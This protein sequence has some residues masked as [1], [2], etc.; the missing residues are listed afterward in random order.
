MA[1]YL[2]SCICKVFLAMQIYYISRKVKNKN[3]I[4]S[5]TINNKQICTTISL[6]FIEIYT[7]I[8]HGYSLSCH[9]L[10]YTIINITKSKFVTTIS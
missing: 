2:Y 7:N 5:P 3:L 6:I 4:D 8:Q 9:W 1:T 10:F